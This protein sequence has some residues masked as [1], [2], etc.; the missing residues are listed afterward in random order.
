MVYLNGCIIESE[1]IIFDLN[2]KVIFA[3]WAVS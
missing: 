2:T 1:E 3:C